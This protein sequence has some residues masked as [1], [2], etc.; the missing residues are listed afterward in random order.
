MKIPI[1]KSLFLEKINIATRFTSH[2]LGTSQALQ[3]INIQCKNGKMDFYSTNLSFYFHTSL[4]IKTEEEASMLIEPKKISE[5][6]NL[7]EQEDV[8]IET[9]KNQIIIS[10]GKTRGAFSLFQAEDFPTPPNID[11]KGEVIE[12][13]F[14][15]K[16]IP[17]VLFSSSKDESRPVLS[18]INFIESDEGLSIV[19]TDGFRLSLLKMKNKKQIKNM[20]I[21][22]EFLYEMAHFAQDEDVIFSFSEEE[23]AVLFSVG[24]NHFYSRLIDGEFPPFEKVIPTE[25]RTSVE[26]DA[27]E[28]LR[29]IKLIAVFA[30]E[31]SNIII[32]HFKK[33][34]LWMSPKLSTG[35]ENSTQTDIKITGDDQKVAF[36][37]KF[38]IDFLNNIKDERVCIEILRP[39]APVVF[40][41]KKNEGF[42]HIIMPVRIQE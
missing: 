14:F 3:G 33:D 22:S 16:N 19:S 12:S 7:L 42:M 36:N 32:C 27:Q 5:F 10:Q 9:G 21:P 20:L 24:D 35:N 15:K 28:L 38:L 1:K 40:K 23:R 2:K 41:T 11:K 6:L 17:L 34:G 26:V 4:P 31:Q 8:E 30:R 25:V 39:D 37:Y 18:G 29:N 13:D